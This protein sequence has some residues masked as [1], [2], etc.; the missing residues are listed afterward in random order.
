MEEN[1][2]KV[3]K[4]TVKNIAI[5]FLSVMLVLTFFSNSI[6][7]RSLPE[8]ATEYVA[9][10]SITER[11]RGTGTVTAQDPYKVICGRTEPTLVG[12]QTHPSV[13]RP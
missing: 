13:L 3:R 9:Y 5:V 10:D 4:D 7:N 1:I 8:V 2:F 6:L 11:I 12:P